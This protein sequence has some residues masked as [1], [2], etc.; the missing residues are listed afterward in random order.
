M[1]TI[2]GE[3]TVVLRGVL[4]QGYFAKRAHIPQELQIERSAANAVPFMVS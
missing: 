1:T 4:N 3:G 2:A